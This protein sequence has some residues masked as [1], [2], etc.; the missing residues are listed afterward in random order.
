MV[1]IEKLDISVVLH[2]MDKDFLPVNV[3][4]TLQ[5]RCDI[6]LCTQLNVAKDILDQS[7]YTK[8][9]GIKHIISVCTPLNV[10]KNIS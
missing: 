1:T 9:C 7:M 5:K 2:P 6:C 4:Q 10:T 3:H 8:P